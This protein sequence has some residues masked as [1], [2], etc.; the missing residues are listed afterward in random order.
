MR[1]QK[2][3]LLGVLLIIIVAAGLFYAVNQDPERREHQLFVTTLKQVAAYSKPYESQFFTS[4]SIKADSAQISL[5]YQTSTGETQQIILS[6]QT[7]NNQ[8]TL[9]YGPGDSALANQTIILE[10]LVKN[11]QVYWK[12]L[13][14]SVLLRFRSKACR[15]GEAIQLI[16]P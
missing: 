5:P 13:N 14:G 12:C 7:A 2:N 9:R 3:S 8:V 15:L 11:N 6:L 4:Q 16:K 10:P 1:M